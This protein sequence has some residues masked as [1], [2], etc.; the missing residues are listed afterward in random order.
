V[1]YP[2]LHS[3]DYAVLIINAHH[4]E[5]ACR[6]WDE[7]CCAINNWQSQLNWQK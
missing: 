6:Q 2:G 7:L 4:E 3:G 1:A 5:V